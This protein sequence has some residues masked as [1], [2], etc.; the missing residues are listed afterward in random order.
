MLIYSYRRNVFSIL[1]LTDTIGIYIRKI[2]VQY[3]IDNIIKI[4]N[5]VLVLAV[6]FY[7]YEITKKVKDQELYKKLNMQIKIIIGLI[8]VTS[9]LFILSY[10]IEFLQSVPYLCIIYLFQ[11][12]L[13]IVCIKERKEL[14]Q[15]EKKD[16]K[17]LTNRENGIKV[18]ITD[19]EEMQLIGSREEFNNNF[20]LYENVS[21]VIN[22]EA[23]GTSGPVIMFQLC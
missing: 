7:V 13:G 1:F 20:S 11:C 10:K 22:L 3:K 17:C 8:I 5:Y 15:E 6:I 4:I 18:L 12:I 21:Y 23:R 2:L 9:I 16:L 14:I 19:G